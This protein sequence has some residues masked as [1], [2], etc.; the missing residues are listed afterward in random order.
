MRPTLGQTIPTVFLSEQ[1]WAGGL[2]SVLAAFL[3][4]QGWIR[5]QALRKETQGRE[6]R[7]AT[8]IDKL[9]A[10]HSEDLRS[11][12]ESI[13]KLDSVEKEVGLLRESMQRN[14]QACDARRD[15]IKTMI[16]GRIGP[17]D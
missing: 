14:C 16:V 5:E 12:V 6:A 2:I 17:K 3:L 8:R 11:V 4:W 10:Q 1:L 9:E 15:E 7:M 13:A